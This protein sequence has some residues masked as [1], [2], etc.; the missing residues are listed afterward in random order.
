MSYKLFLDDMREPKEVYYYYPQKIYLEEDWVIVRS[1]D[2]FMETILE[3]GMPEF[4]SFDHDLADEHY[5]LEGSGCQYDDYKEKTGYDCAIWLAEHIVDNLLP[6]PDYKVHSMNPIGRDNIIH[7]LE[8]L[9]KF[10]K[11]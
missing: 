3:K 8:N 4:V 11:L 5:G 10:Y 7:Y 6:L 1:Y 2:E 9:R